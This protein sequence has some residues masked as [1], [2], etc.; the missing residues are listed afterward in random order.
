MTSQDDSSIYPALLEVETI[1]ALANLN[2]ND[3][4]KK[5]EHLNL[6]SD[7]LIYEIAEK[8]KTDKRQS[9]VLADL[10]IEL[11]VGVDA[12]IAR[13]LARSQ[14]VGNRR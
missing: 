10:L 12:D 3:A 1:D 5:A 7:H 13:R 8:A 6:P 9:R 14:S 11:L 2:P 4:L